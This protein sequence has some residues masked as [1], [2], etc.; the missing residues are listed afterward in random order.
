MSDL[1]ESS[2]VILDLNSLFYFIKVL[3]RSKLYECILWML[4]FIMYQGLWT[5]HRKTEAAF[6]WTFSILSLIIFS[7]NFL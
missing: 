2:Y 4:S 3:Y 5:F 7:I 1:Y 6:A